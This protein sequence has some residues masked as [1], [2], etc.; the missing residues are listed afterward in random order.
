MNSRGKP[1]TP[2]ENFKARFEQD[3]SY[4]PARAQQFAHKIDGQWA[5]LLWPY[6]GGDNIVDDE[7]MRYIEFLTE[8]CELRDGRMGSGNLTSRAHSTYGEENP[9]AA[10]HLDFLFAALDCWTG[11]QHINST[12]DDLFTIAE[13]GADAYDNSKVVVFNIAGVNLFEMCCHTFEGKPFGQRAFT[14][15]Q[16]LYLYAVLLH[17]IDATDDFPRRI[18]TLRNLIAASDDEIRR[19]NMPELVADV[20]H[21]I[22]NDDLDAVK[23]FST[24]QLADERLKREFLAEHP[25][26]TEAVYR[27]EDHPLLRGTLAC[28]EYNPVRFSQHAQAFEAAFSDPSHWAAITGALLA[29]GDYQRPRTKGWQFGTGAPK[30]S[31]VW[32]RLLT[33]ASRDTLA[34][35]RGVLDVFLDG[36]AGSAQS[37]GDYCAE[38]M[39]AW[40]VEREHDGY[41]DWRYYLV[42]YP[43]LR[44]GLTGIYIGSDGNLGYSMCMLNATQL[45][46]Y[47]RDPILLG[48][49]ELSGIG[50]LAAHQWFIGYETLPRWLRLARSYTGLRSVPEGF[51]LERPADQAA[52]TTFEALCAARDD[53]ITDSERTL[54]EIPQNDDAIDEVDRVVVGAA[55]LKEF[56]AAGL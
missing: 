37:V 52:A 43:S 44:S 2:F 42:K 23:R 12:F 41:F 3:I 29:T 47:Y 25:D 11:E 40:L 19:Q 6:H 5:D 1:L 26:L 30:N 51:E 9:R 36:L 14:L 35:T 15:Q 22:V 53:I 16:S 38:V 45:N 50:E 7:F 34:P 48:A 21:V 24:N 13:P 18:R 46:G 20:E 56:A 8:I 54:L 4:D 39:A 49:W 33:N 32:R 17:L 28:F 31:D 27:L 55:L 10:E